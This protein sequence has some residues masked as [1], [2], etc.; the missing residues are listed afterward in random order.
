M[1]ALLKILLILPIVLLTISCSKNEPGEATISI[2]SA[3]TTA[4]SDEGTVVFKG[5]VKATTGVIDEI[6]IMVLYHGKNKNSQTGKTENKNIAELASNITTIH[7][8]FTKK[9]KKEYEFH[10]T[11]KN[12][13]IAL[14]RTEIY[15]IKVNVR[16]QDG[17]RF[18]TTWP[19]R[20][21]YKM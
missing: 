10:L 4:I 9:S 11:E 1:K 14:R 20:A 17:E 8:G 18:S 5:D 12:E 13:I 15:A 2:D 6:S 3:S 21:Q 19:I 7:D 16:M